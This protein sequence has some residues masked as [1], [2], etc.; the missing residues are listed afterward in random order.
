MSPELEEL[1]LF[2]FG[3]A[4]LIWLSRKPLRHPRSHG[5]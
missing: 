3:T 2:A 5:F 1:L 4:V